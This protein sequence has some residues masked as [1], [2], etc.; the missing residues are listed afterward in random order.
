MMGWGLFIRYFYLGR[1]GVV[2]ATDP[3]IELVIKLYKTNTLFS[4]YTWSWR[5]LLNN[6][7]TLLNL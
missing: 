3:A 5:L 6:I 7:P 4:R 2:S 1:D